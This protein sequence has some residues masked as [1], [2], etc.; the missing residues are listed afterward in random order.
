MNRKFLLLACLSI[1]SLFSYSQN[2]LSGGQIHGNFQVDAQTYTPDSNIGAPD[3]PEKFGMNSYANLVYTNGGLTAGI[4][5]EGYLNT[6]QGYDGKYDGTGLPFRFATY[7]MEH[8][9]VTAGSFYEQFGSGLILRSYEEK[10]LGYDNAFDGFRVKVQMLK[11]I[12][13]KGMVGKQ[14]YF[15]DLGPG[16]VRGIDGEISLNQTIKKLENTKTQVILGGSFVSKFQSDKDP[17]LVLPENVAAWAGRMNLNRGKVNIYGE[18]AYKIN[19]PSSDNGNIYKNGQALIL[20]M[21]YSTKGFG[22]LLSAKR[23]DNMSFRSD[24]NATLANLNINYLPVITKTYTYTLL[25]M[26]P[27]AT[28]PNGEM[29]IQ[30]ELMYKFK[31]ETTLGGKY[32]T[33]VSV[34]YSRINSIK[35]TAVNDTTAIGE[36]GTLGYRSDFF[37]LGDELFFQ[38]FNIEVNKKISKK[39]LTNFVYQNLAYNYN[40]LRG[41]TGHEM[42][43]ANNLVADI[44]WKFKEK[45]SIRFEGQALFTEQDMGNWCMLTVEYS[46]APSWF[47]TAI[48]QYNYGNEDSD[49]RFHYMQGAI[50]YAKASSRISVGYGKQREGVM[51][52][53]G[54]CRNVP[55]S[56]GF[57][58]AISSSF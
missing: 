34:N 46:I 21:S 20:N 54:V 28:Q 36:Y 12:T 58:V 1:F 43:Y 19:D 2:V 52:V 5:Y 6:L 26:Y 38:D 40:V 4:R 9:E 41:V 49:K 37:T 55:A 50:V 16:I 29:G 47:F 15:F 35:E 14:R 23:L 11:G 33:N 30:G 48:D 42:V 27:F 39:I 31:K 32:G 44:T 17:K 56:N 22:L 57:I 45:Q 3:V 25:A 24:R 51:C 10:G 13:I 8:L 7:T 53:G 18:Y